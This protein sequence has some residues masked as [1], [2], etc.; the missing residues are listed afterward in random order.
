MRNRL[1][2]LMAI[3]C[4]AAFA[5]EGQAKE[6]RMAVQDLDG[7]RLT[8]TVPGA[9]HP[10]VLNPQHP[11]HD[12]LSV[13]AELAF[14]N[15]SSDPIAAPLEEIGNGLVRIYA[16]ENEPAPVIDNRIPPP[17]VDGA[18]VSLAPGG[19]HVERRRID[20]P[21]ILSRPKKDA[22][23]ALTFCLEWKAEWLR[24]SNYAAGAVQWNPDFRLCETVMVS[25]EAARPRR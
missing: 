17:P 21:P 11:D 18:V 20:A 14:E 24:Q 19:R 9:V 22:P 25:L 8:L 16:V 3:A 12:P 1:T 4:A 15:I 7:V 10:D 6:E 2:A 13:V 23:V 5:G